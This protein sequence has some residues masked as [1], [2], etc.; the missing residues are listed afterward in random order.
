MT[1]NIVRFILPDHTLVAVKK[2]LNNKYDFELTLPNGNRKTFIWSAND[3]N[4]FSD[5]NGKTDKRITEA[6]QQFSETLND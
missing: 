2:A 4:V 6:I 1:N 5:R 3:G